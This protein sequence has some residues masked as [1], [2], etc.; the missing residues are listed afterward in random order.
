MTRAQTCAKCE[1]E[2]RY[3]KRGDVTGWLHRDPDA[4]HWPAFGTLWTP[5]HQAQADRAI[6]ERLAAKKGAGKAEEDEEEDA[7]NWDSIP[8]PEVRCTDVDASIFPPR[9]GILQIINLIEK[10]D[11]WDLRRITYARGPYVGARG[12]VLSIS[13]HHKVSAVGPIV[14][15]DGLDSGQRFV[16]ASWRDL[17]FD[18]GYTGLIRDRVVYPTIAN[19]TALKAWIKETL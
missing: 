9:S 18:A 4:D 10:T 17:K 16:V 19:S 12:Q 14:E 15:G 13:D 6:R 8:E 5:E 7:D 3:G 1:E 2:V 11:G